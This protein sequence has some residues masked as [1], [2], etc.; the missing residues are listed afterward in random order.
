MLVECHKRQKDRYQLGDKEW[1]DGEAASQL[2]L[3][4]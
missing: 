3:E 1:L 4:R 2:G